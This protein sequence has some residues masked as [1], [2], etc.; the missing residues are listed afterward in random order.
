[1]KNIFELLHV[2]SILHN[3]ISQGKL[4]LERKKMVR[5]CFL[6]E[7]NKI[8]CLTGKNNAIWKELMG[9]HFFKKENNLTIKQENMPPLGPCF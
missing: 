6:A 9:L 2:S 5:C 8:L 1:M 4:S 3:A 7:K